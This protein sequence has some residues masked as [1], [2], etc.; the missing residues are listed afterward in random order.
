MALT[1]SQATQSERARLGQLTEDP[2]RRVLT[3]PKASLPSA[4][5]RVRQLKK[6]GVEELV[7]QGKTRIGR[8]GILGLGTVG[9]VVEAV[10][11]EGV[12]AVKIRRL[13]ANRQDMEAEAAMT[14][15]ANRV[16]VGPVVYAH[17]KDIILME[18][19]RYV[20][21]DEWLSGIRAPG[22]RAP[23]REM[24]HSILNQCRKLDLMGI[25]HG[26]LSNLRKHVVVAD[27]EP[28][29]IDFESAS[30]G[31][32]PKNVTAAAQHLLVGGGISPQIRRLLGLR[33]T[34]PLL[35]LLSRYKDDTSD[36][37]YSKLLELL[38]LGS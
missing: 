34:R 17:T 20:E 7:F 11:G 27:G 28:R 19:I 23:A 32:R 1:Q 31:R 38:K 9:V 8:L 36:F 5:S 18:L 10:T 35:G 24:V 33:D 26:Q 25:D 15:A 29:I 30:L 12:R 2:Y 3:Y 22:G 13:D 4:R 6:L 21:L 16:G 14:V 37:T